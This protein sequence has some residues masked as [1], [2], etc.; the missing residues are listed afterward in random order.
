M[1]GHTIASCYGAIE[2]ASFHYQPRLLDERF[3]AYATEGSDF[4]MWVFA[5]YL[6]FQRVLWEWPDHLK[7]QKE[8]IQGI[9]RTLNEIIGR[10]P[11]EI[12]PAK[13]RSLQDMC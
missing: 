7:G 11:E 2:T 6:E 13:Y 12:I 4:I 1:N 10:M 3:T 9:R 8:D 5:L